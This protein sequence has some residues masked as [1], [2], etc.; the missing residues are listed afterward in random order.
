MPPPRSL[1]WEGLLL[2]SHCLQGQ[3]SEQEARQPGSRRRP[4]RAPHPGDPLRGAA[5]QAE[6]TVTQR[7]PR[8]R[9]P[10][11]SALGTRR[12]PTGQ[13]QGPQAGLS[14]HLGGPGAPARLPQL[15]RGRGELEELAP[16]GPPGPGPPPRGRPAPSAGPGPAGSSAPGPA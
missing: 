11:P 4:P 5:S 13:E 12:I 6:D 7:R 2:C 3:R 14:S 9:G 10:P 15:S 16:Q 8:G 1:P